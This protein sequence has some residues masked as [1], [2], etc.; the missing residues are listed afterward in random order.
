MF[1]SQTLIA[2][3]TFALASVA[4]ITLLVNWSVSKSQLSELSRQNDLIKQQLNLLEKREQ[5]NLKLINFKVEKNTI[6]LGLINIGKS[7]AVGIG[8]LG[9]IFSY[10]VSTYSGKKLT[11][12]GFPIT[13]IKIINCMKLG[14]L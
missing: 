6:E 4:F 8:I 10:G 14:I 12:Q 3:A 11:I 13:S 9:E 5:P 1:D 7:D 2:I